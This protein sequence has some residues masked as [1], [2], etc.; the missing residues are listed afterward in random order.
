MGEFKELY[1]A[2]GNQKYMGEVNA[3]DRYH[4]KGRAFYYSGK[5]AY[6]GEYRENKFNGIG[7]M[8]YT[9][10]SL[11]FQG[12]FLN[13]MKH[14]IGRVFAPDGS[15]MY[16]GEFYNDARHGYGREFCPITGEIEYQGN[17]EN[18]KRIDDKEA[19]ETKKRVAIG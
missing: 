4:G 11:A 2:N 15:V 13:N 3:N 9:D 6:E 10:G 5:I 1:Y 7:M 8:Y 19:I 14:G 17:F 18:G 12:E 16:E